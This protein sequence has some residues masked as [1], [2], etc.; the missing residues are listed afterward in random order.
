M[1]ILEYFVCR[2]DSGV[3]NNQGV[4]VSFSTL[5]L[6]EFLLNCFSLDVCAKLE[7]QIGTAQHCVVRNERAE[8][9]CLEASQCPSDFTPV[10]SSDAETHNN[11][12]LMKIAGCKKY[13]ARDTTTAVAKG[14]CRYGTKYLANVYP[15]IS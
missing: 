13:G 5:T 10:C 6:V 3:E 12:C 11:V 8:I 9:V 2:L 14:Q 4:N 1:A 7:T 15:F